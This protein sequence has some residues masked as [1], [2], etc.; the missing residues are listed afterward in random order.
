MQ[1]STTN[2]EVA[3][4]L[5]AGTPVQG[6]GSMCTTRAP[7]FLVN[8]FRRSSRR[9]PGLMP[10]NA[11]AW[12]SAYSSCAK[13]SEFWATASTLSLLPAAGPAFQSSSRA[14]RRASERG[15]ALPVERKGAQLG[16]RSHERSQDDHPRST[17]LASHLRKEVPI[18]HRNESYRQIASAAA[19][20]NG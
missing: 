4:F 1:S 5:A 10:H 16:G 7:E 20:G 12:A 2:Q 6:S 3:S 17:G 9:S 14:R 19:S 11:T 8:R 13:R 18:P 15:R